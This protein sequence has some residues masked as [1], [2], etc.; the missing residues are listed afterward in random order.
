MSY[1][2]LAATPS[3][4]VDGRTARR[5]AVN[6]EAFVRDTEA[7]VA[8]V[9]VTDLSTDG[10]K[11]VSALAFETETTIWLKIS[12][13]AARQLRIIWREGEV[14]QNHV[15]EDLSAARQRELRGQVSANAMKLRQGR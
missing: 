8:V 3:A 12:G 15:V 9:E 7:S 4:K 11:F 2:A 5:R 10:C 6:F 14:M 1:Q 13:I